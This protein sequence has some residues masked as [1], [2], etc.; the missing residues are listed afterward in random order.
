MLKQDTIIKR[1]NKAFALREEYEIKENNKVDTKNDSIHKVLQRAKKLFMSEDAINYARR[2]DVDFSFVN[3]QTT[4]KSR[5]NAKSLVKTAQLMSALFSKA[6]HELDTHTHAIVKQALHMKQAR[7]YSQ[8]DLCAMQTT[9]V[10]TS[11]STSLDQ[12]ARSTYTVNTAQSQ[13]SSSKMSF[14]DLELATK[15]NS[16]EIEL[17]MQ[18]IR[19]AFDAE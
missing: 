18:A 16:R 13:A 8:S 5:R 1:I 9:K 2:H 6:I 17:D 3:V 7:T 15:H 14:V 10:T 4:A 19:D 11:L 12:K